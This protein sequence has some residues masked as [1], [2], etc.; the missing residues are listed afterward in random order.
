[1]ATQAPTG[2]TETTT[3]AER[4]KALPDRVVYL[5]GLAVFLVLSL[6]I[7]FIW[8][9][10]IGFP[11]EFGRDLARWVDDV[12]DWIT[13]NL[14]FILDPISNAILRFLVTLEDFLKWIPW[15]ILIIGVTA[16]GYKAA[17]RAVG[18]FS[19]A[20]LLLLG[21]FGLWESAMETLSLIIVS[22]ITS[23]VIAIPVGILAARNNTLDA[24]LRPILDAMQ[25]MPAFVYLVPAIMF[26]GLGDQ[27]GVLATVIYAVPPAIRL[28]N[29]GIRQVS[30][31]I[32]EAARSFGTSNRQLLWKVQVPMAVPT[33]MAGINQT[34]MMALA[35]VVI[36]S[37]VGAGGLGDDVNRALS[38]F[39]PGKALNGGI[40]I[41][42]L[43][44]IIDRLTQAA[45]KERQ[46][47]LTGG[48]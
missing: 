19:L 30:P 16:M 5:G 12:I 20:S 42:I 3:I 27:A 13:V 2:E 10:G 41:V 45:A 18:I 44:I 33:I 39:Q 9:D 17:G 47:A 36:A 28:T 38:Q 24:L 8:R 32:V 26:F 35:M 46:K 11:V 34:T 48:H 1:M 43:A 29:L 37:L 25:T 40:G 7:T 31:N 21:G 4:F 14:N 15:P 23:I 6:I 22:V